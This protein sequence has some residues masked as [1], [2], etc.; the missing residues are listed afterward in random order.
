MK[1]LISYFELTINKSEGLYNWVTNGNIIVLGKYDGTVFE[2]GDRLSMG[3]MSSNNQVKEI[4]KDKIVISEG[5]RFTNSTFISFFNPVIIKIKG[6]GAWGRKNRGSQQTERHIKSITSRVNNILPDITVNNSE[7]AF[8]T[9]V[10]QILNPTI[11]TE[12][13]AG[14]QESLF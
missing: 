4:F 14:K 1:Q 8:N 6:D 13:R 2:G 10:K 9:L 5:D 12:N 7:E 3:V 11:N